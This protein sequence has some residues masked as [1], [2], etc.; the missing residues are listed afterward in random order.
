[1]SAV[2]VVGWTQG[3]GILMSLNIPWTIMPT[4][5]NPVTL[6]VKTKYIMSACVCRHPCKLENYLAVSLL[7]FIGNVARFR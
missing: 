5:E 4:Q 2:I 7:P 3:L 6:P 1:M